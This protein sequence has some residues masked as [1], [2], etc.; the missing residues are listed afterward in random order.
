MKVEELDLLI[1]ALDSLDRAFDAQE[2]IYNQE[3]VMR[4]HRKLRQ[5]VATAKVRAPKGA[6]A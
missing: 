6:A 5:L 4:A 1:M 2:L 3:D